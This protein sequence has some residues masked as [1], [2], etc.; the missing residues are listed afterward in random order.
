MMRSR[1]LL[2]FS[3]QALAGHRL[4]TALILVAMAIGVASVVVL[5]ALGE[6]AR[7]Y[8][9]DQFEALGSHLL[10]V[11]PGRAETTGGAPPLLGETPRPLTLDD[12]LALRR[13]ASVA[14]IAPLA[15]GEAQASHGNRDRDALVVGTTASLATIMGLKMARGRFLPAADPRQERPLAVLGHRLA[16]ELFG[17]RP[18]VGQWIR[19]G[20]RRFR[21]IG[22]LADQGETLGMQVRDDLFVPVASAQ[23]L[24]DTE[25]LARILVQARG[26]EAIDDA[27]RAI[28]TRLTARHDGELDVTILTQKAMVATFDRILTALTL[29][30]AGIAAISLA[31]AGILI[32]N[33]MLIAVA[34]RTA[35]IG[36]LKALGAPRRQI[37]ALFLTDATLLSGLGGLLGLLLGLLGTHLLG[38]LFPSFPVS[39]PPWAAAGA[40][41]MAMATGLLF[42]I[43]PARKAARLDPVACL[44]GR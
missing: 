17:N 42:G 27:E 43:L 4:R 23:A 33:V 15:M 29:T 39:A 38:Q 16:R 18:A 6:G 3:L 22:V 20:P 13:I 36:L 19:L 5:T 28:A 7:R 8:V 21:V 24:F 25:S 40:L 35:E 37:T 30:V 12:A 32:M 11:L 10:I 2:G 26:R 34:Q 14:A 9:A 41:G 1:D 31:V 44:T